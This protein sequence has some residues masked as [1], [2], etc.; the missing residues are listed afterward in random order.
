MSEVSTIEKILLKKKLEQFLEEDI[1]YGDITSKILKNT[2][3]FAQILYKSDGLVCGI[4]EAELL[5]EMGN[6][7][8]LNTVSDGDELKKGTEVMRLS[9][10]LYDI[11]S[12]ERTLLNIMM[13]MSSI[14]STT[15]Q[16]STLIQQTG[17]SVKIAVY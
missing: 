9:G 4:Q 1:R 7:M 14:A 15:F 16:F 11:L 17:E 2:K 3:V 10:K 5:C 8:V 12:I 13:R 6:I